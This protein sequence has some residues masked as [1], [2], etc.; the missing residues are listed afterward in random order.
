MKINKINKWK[1]MRVIYV[2][3]K[4][5]KFHEK[6]EKNYIEI[7]ILKRRGVIRSRMS[8]EYEWKWR[9]VGK[10]HAFSNVRFHTR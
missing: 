8:E 1:Y 5:N 3:N 4:S 7:N 2:V 6:K 10:P 9:K